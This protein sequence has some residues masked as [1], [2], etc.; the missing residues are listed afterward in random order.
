[1]SNLIKPVN[2]D[3]SQLT[4]QMSQLSLRSDSDSLQNTAEKVANV[5]DP[6]V[7][8]QLCQMSRTQLQNLGVTYLPFNNK[9][10]K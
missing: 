10:L 3:T 4:E 8:S 1:M 2:A 6:K 7:Y 5:I 9:N